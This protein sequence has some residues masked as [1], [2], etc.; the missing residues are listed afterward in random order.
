NMCTKTVI[1]TETAPHNHCAGDGTVV[2]SMPE[3]PK[4][5]IVWSMASLY[6]GKPFCL[7]LLAFYFSVKSRDRKMVGGLEGVRSYGSTARCINGWALIT[8]FVIFG[9]NSSHILATV[10][11]LYG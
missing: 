1:K 6:F 3:H 11:I 2:S 4:D 7:G 9:K 10:N 5:Y 8:L